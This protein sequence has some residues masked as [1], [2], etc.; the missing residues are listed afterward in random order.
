MNLGKTSRQ[1]NATQLV[2]ERFYDQ[3]FLAEI[4]T[5]GGNTK[6]RKSKLEERLAKEGKPF[7]EIVAMQKQ[8]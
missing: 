4:I 5:P 2:F 7:R 8:D 6:F 1:M 3:Y